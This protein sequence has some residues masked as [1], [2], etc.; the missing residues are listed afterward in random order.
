ML[1]G[2]MAKREPLSDQAIEAFVS[3]H[4]GWARVDERLERSF[5]FDDYPKTLA[6]VVQ[7]G[8]AAEKRDHHPDLL[9]GYGKVTVRWTTHDTSPPGRIS[10]VD[11]EMAERSDRIFAG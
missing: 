4:P 6:F 7:L 11:T 5:A 10:A 3:A 8:F 2:P 9:V 1:A